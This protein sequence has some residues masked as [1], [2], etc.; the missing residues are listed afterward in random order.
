MVQLADRFARLSAKIAVLSAAEWYLI[1]KV[2][3]DKMPAFVLNHVWSLSIF[4]SFLL[5]A[6]YATFIYPFYV[7]PLRHLPV[8]SVCI[9]QLYFNRYH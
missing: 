2:I 5:F 8:V 7:S 4:T 1:T 9:H 6:S 3:D